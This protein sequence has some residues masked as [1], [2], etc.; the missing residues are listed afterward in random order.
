MY[1][2]IN[3]LIFWQCKWFDCG[4]DYISINWN[5]L[6]LILKYLYISF[7]FYRLEVFPI[8]LVLQ[9]FSGIYA[10]VS[11]KI[12]YTSCMR[13]KKKKNKPK[14][15]IQNTSI[16]LLTRKGWQYISSLSRWIVIISYS[17]L[18]LLCSLFIKL[19]SNLQR[20]SAVCGLIFVL[21]RLVYAAGYQSGGRSSV[22]LNIPCLLI[23][24]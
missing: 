14:T 23:D 11:K 8:Y 19:C 2:K 6:I 17:W 12:Y 24:L 7:H 1:M 4:M 15:Q 20:F 13:G 5:V 3:H 10:P 22:S 16:T 21:G 9:I 18:K